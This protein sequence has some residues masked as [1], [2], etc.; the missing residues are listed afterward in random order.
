MISEYFLN[1]MDEFAQ[2]NDDGSE[3][4]LHIWQLQRERFFEL[5]FCCI[6]ADSECLN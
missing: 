4:L 6:C 3:L 5:L 2:I 1:L